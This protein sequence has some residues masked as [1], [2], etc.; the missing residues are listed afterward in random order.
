MAARIFPDPS[1]EPEFIAENG[2]RYKWSDEKSR[3]EVVSSNLT[4]DETQAQIDTIKGDI[5]TLQKEIEELST[6]LE[7]GV[8][9]H[10]ADH[11]ADDGNFVVGYGNPEQTTQEWSEVA[12]MYFKPQDL[13]G[14]THGF[15]GIN[16]HDRIELVNSAGTSFGLY[17]VDNSVDDTSNTLSWAFVVH[18]IRGK[19]ELTHDT[20]F[21]VQFFRLQQSGGGI[22]LDDA[23]NRYEKMY[24]AGPIGSIVFWPGERSKIPSGWIECKGQ[25]ASSYT[26]WKNATGKST[27]P[28][29]QDYMPA[30]AGGRFGS[31]IGSNVNSKLKKHKH[32]WGGP[33]DRKGYPKDSADTSDGSGVR[34]SYWRGNKYNSNSTSSGGVYTTEVGDSSFS[35]P[36]VSLGIW[37]TRVS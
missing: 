24:N 10:K 36:P 11:N 13:N 3:W 37:I 12:V 26:A 16:V 30:G 4:S 23:D 32:I 35:A 29:L 2:I 19:G 27:I 22:S 8:W 28:K 18:L 20:D 25:S 17:E 15:G 14:D 34:Y 9:T 7:N 31:T 33:E 6:N 1:S 21:T 5:V